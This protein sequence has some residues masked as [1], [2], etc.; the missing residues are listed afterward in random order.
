MIEQLAGP[1]VEDADH[2]E[3]GADEPWILGQFEQCR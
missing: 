1:G 3:A 2:A